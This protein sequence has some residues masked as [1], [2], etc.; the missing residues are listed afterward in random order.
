ME[1]IRGFSIFKKDR[2]GLPPL[3]ARLINLIMVLNTPLSIPKS[4]TVMKVELRSKHTTANMN[5]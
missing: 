1:K 2:G 5:D 4:D 3:V